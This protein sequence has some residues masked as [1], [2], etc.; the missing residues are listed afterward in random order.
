MYIEVRLGD[1]VVCRRLGEERDIAYADLHR[2]GRAL[3]TA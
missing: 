3:R 1:R 2:D